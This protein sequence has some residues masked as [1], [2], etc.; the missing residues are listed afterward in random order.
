MSNMVNQQG[1]PIEEQTIFPTWGYE[2]SQEDITK[3]I[4]LLCEHLNIEIVHTNATK[5]GNYEYQLRS[6]E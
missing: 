1:K 2:R 4:S 3:T 6:A 5:H